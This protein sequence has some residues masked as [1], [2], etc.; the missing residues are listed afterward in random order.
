MALTN[1]TNH[2]KTM[3][4]GFA[5]KASGLANGF[6]GGIAGLMKSASGSQAKVAAQLLKKSPFEVPDSPIA[7][8]TAD[9]LQFSHVSYPRD[10]ESNGLGHYIIFYAMSNSYEDVQ[11]DIKKGGY[12]S[13][14]HIMDEVALTGN[15]V[16]NIRGLNGKLFTP[17][18]SNNSVLSKIV[19]ARTATAAISLYMPPGI[20]VKYSMDYELG[21]TAIAGGIVKAYGEGGKG[22]GGLKE[23]ITTGM[24][25]AVKTGLK[26]SVDAI[27]DALGAGKPAQL[28]DKAMGI[29][30][31]PHEEM[32]FN[33]PN[34]RS[35]DYAFDFY[36]KNK[37]EMED[38]NKIIMLFKYHMHPSI[39]D[40]IH[41][42]VPSEFEIHYAYLGQEN[43]YLN[44]ISTCV[45]K[46]MDVAYGP[47]EQWSTFKP[48]NKGAPP[49][50]TK[51]TL[52]FE[53]TQY[54]TKKEITE[55]Y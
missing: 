31:N 24:A 13:T 54:I 10:L 12:V 47:E 5:D 28:Y 18:K 9:P 51:L 19:K 39:S 30:I 25:G 3:A 4:T 50:T 49:V 52:K 27:A 55:G 7:K 17:I 35:F 45:L 11:A 14:T 41:F 22:L 46:N 32:F 38:V 34:F 42:K 6:T 33:K 8:A 53:E 16:K 15:V 40:N 2:L 21:S 44:K 37:L 20:E 1:V 36:P 29:A 48:T 23:A 43:E 26:K